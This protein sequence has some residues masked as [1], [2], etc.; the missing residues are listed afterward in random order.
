M[1]VH[2]LVRLFWIPLWIASKRSKLL[3]SPLSLCWF[4]GL[5][6]AGVVTHLH[7][8]HDHNMFVQ[9]RGRKRFRL[10]APENWQVCSFSISKFV[11]EG[12]WLRHKCKTPNAQMQNAQM[13]NAQMPKFQMPKCTRYECSNAQILNAKCPKAQLQNAKCQMPKCIA[14]MPNAQMQKRT[15]AQMQKCKNAKCQMWKTPWGVEVWYSPTVF[16]STFLLVLG[17][18]LVSTNPPNVAQVQASAFGYGCGTSSMFC[19]VVK[20]TESC[21]AQSQT[22]QKP[23]TIPSLVFWNYIVIHWLTTMACATKLS[24]VATENTELNWTP[25]AQ[26]QCQC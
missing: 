3:N 8:D 26:L 25:S 15:T 18:A 11:F 9:I 16:V 23:N 20:E 6:D 10:F 1:H 2:F 13:S 12:Y 24:A 7:G 17:L 5:V 22:D 19:T 14:A 4:G 21:C